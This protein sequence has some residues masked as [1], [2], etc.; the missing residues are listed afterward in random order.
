MAR[1]DGPRV[2]RG[3][4]GRGAGGR[5]CAWVSAPCRCW[6]PAALPLL[7]GLAALYP[8]ARPDAAHHFGNTFYLNAP[9]FAG[10]GVVYSGRLVRAGLAGAAGAQLA[11]VAPAGLF[12]LAITT[13]FAAIDTTM[14]LDPH[15][16]ST[17]YGMVTAASMGCWRCP[18]A[19]LLTAGDVRADRFAADLGKLLL[20]LVGA[21]DLPRLHPAADR[22]AVQ[23]GGGG[24]LVSPARTRP[25]GRAVAG[26]AAGHF[27]LPF[28]LLLS[29]RMQRSRRVVLFVAGLLVGDAVLRSWWTVLPSLARGV[30]WI[31]LACMV[32]LGG[33]AL[34]FAR[35]A[36]RRVAGDGDGPC[37][38][39]PPTA[40]FRAARHEKRDIGLRFM[41]MLLSGIGCTLL[42]L[43]ALAYV[44][45]PGEVKDRRFA[46]PF[47]NFP[48][49]RCS[50]ARPSTGRCSTRARWRG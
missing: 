14:S 28:F 21:V 4:L 42:L 38:S 18:M 40:R 41:L 17:I 27:V 11:P 49:P 45:Y 16:T 9:F 5:R 26:D 12:A 44:I 7:P 25:V 31:A 24:A 3:T 39:T 22:L 47:P 30:D 2:D 15:F 34:G 32:G 46:E 20:A 23:P 6:W 43:M 33:A 8:W 50:P 1:A 29:P 48:K 37:L 19:V 13:T 10:R 35:W 36:G